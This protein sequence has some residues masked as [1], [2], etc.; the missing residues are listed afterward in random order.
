MLK[1]RSLNWQVIHWLI[2][3]MKLKK[4][5]LII[6]NRSA[7]EIEDVERFSGWERDRQRWEFLLALG[8]KKYSRA[9]SLGRNLITKK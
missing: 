5:V 1:I 6:G 2:L 7:I 9:I 8:E 3:I 4:S